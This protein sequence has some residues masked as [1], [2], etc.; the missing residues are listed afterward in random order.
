MV[1]PVP[2]PNAPKSIRDDESQVKPAR[3]TS[4]RKTAKG[5]KAFALGRLPTGTMNKTEAR[6]MLFLEDEV[7]A[8]RVIWFAFEPIKFRLAK[9]TF[10]TPD[11]LVMMADR[12]LEV[13]E[14]KGFWM[15]DARVKIKV[16]ADRFPVFVFRAIKAGKGGAWEEETF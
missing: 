1:K 5:P 10:Y 12:S 7:R 6:Y 16:A 2:A 4:R 8:G 13:H 11:F 3:N 14:V 15:D 9:A